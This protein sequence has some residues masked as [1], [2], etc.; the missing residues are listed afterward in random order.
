MHYI[1]RKIKQFYLY[2]RE[3]TLS[4]ADRVFS[5]NVKHAVPKTI[6]SVFTIAPPRIGD[7]ALAAPIFQSL[8]N[9]YPG[10]DID[11]LCNKYT[12]QLLS[13]VNGI[14]H[15]IVLEES[16]AAK[17]RFVFQQRR[18]KHDM[19]IDLNFDYHLWPA[20]IARASGAYSIGYNISGRG[21][22]FDMKIPPPDSHRH[23]TDI[24][25]DLLG[26][27]KHNTPT[28]KPHIEIPSELSYE[29]D[30]LLAKQGIERGDKVLLIHPGAHH[31]TQRWL[32]RY[33][34]EVADKI[35]EEKLA[36]LVFI[37]GPGEKCLI[38]SIT[39]SM[40]NSPDASF[41]NLEIKNIA[42]LIKRVDI[43]ICNNSGPLHIAV[44]AKTPTI[45]TMGPTVKDRWTPLGEIH[46]VFRIDDLPCIGCNLGYCRIQSHDCMRLITPS[47]VLEAI[48]DLIS[49]N[50]YS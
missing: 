36:K 10:A 4:L 27:S 34:S 41:L 18:L 49:N 50:T 20:V 46:K 8:K 19:A 28:T 44:A 21:L 39:S 30:S 7:V 3:L 35:I 33:F 47:I 16:L 11:V 40:N 2:V 26:S 9:S 42:A 15:I 17:C 14:D 12:S 6:N 37:G 38:E 29:T 48:R 5:T 32:P 24:F 22:F 45:S 1:K 31:P 43:L 25:Y 13:L 23:A